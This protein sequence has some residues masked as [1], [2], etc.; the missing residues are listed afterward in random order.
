MNDF[1]HF[2]RGAFELL[3]QHQRI[4]MDR[5][6]GGAVNGSIRHRHESEPRTDIDNCGRRFL[7]QMFDKE[8]SHVYQSRKINRDFIA[9][10]FECGVAFLEVDISLYPGVVHQNIDVRETAQ[11]FRG[12]FLPLRS[13]A[14]I[15]GQHHE[16]RESFLYFR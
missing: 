7:Q 13:I 16:F 1:N 2:D 15:T 11:Y 12:Q 8:R 14:D 5:G 10:G 4:G 3:P 9:A 6:F